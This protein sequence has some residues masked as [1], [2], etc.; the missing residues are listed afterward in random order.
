VLP[1]Y[2]VF[3]ASNASF[4][5]ER[6]VHIFVE[7]TQK[8]GRLSATPVSLAGKHRFPLLQADDEQFGCKSTMLSTFIAGATPK[9]CV[10]TRHRKPPAG[11]NGRGFAGKFLSVRGASRGRREAPRSRK[12]SIFE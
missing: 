2:S 12:S 9:N 7:K 1:G 11:L 8:R 6:M 3:D 4:A 5:A 10:E